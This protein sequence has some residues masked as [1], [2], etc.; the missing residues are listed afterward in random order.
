MYIDCV[1]CIG[2]ASMCTDNTSMLN[3]DRSMHIVD[4]FMCIRFIHVH[5]RALIYIGD[6]LLCI[7]DAS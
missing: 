7:V 2:L 3:N 4:A 5:G 6:P 1:L